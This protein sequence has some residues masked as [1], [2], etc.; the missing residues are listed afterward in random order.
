[1]TLVDSGDVFVS[2]CLYMRTYRKCGKDTRS[3]I[4]VPVQIIP[5]LCEVVQSTLSLNTHAHTHTHRIA[6]LLLL[7]AAMI[8]LIKNNN[9]NNNY[10]LY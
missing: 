9:N 7:V 3:P 5:F 10:M 4:V 2:V 8:I 6:I 1:M